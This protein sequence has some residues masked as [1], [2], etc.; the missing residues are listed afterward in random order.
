MRP[1]TPTS[2]AVTVFGD[3]R[4]MYRATPLAAL[5]PARRSR[6]SSTAP[7]AAAIASSSAPRAGPGC[8]A[9]ITTALIAGVMNSTSVCAAREAR[10]REPAST[11]LLMDTATNSS[12]VSAPA[13]PAT[14]T[15]KSCHI[16]GR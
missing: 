11:S 6:T 16:S 3:A 15:P 4:S 8:G 13:R 12:P 5:C 10:L 1:A 9:T 2:A 7:E 14:A